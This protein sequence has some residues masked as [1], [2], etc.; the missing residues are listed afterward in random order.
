MDWKKTGTIALVIVLLLGTAGVF[1]LLNQGPAKENSRPI[2]SSKETTDPENFKK[3]DSGKGIAVTTVYL[4]PTV[5]SEN[6]MFYI[7]LDTH[8]G[9]LF[10]YEIPAISKLKVNGKV[11]TPVKWE[12][13]PSSW[14]H[15]R[16]GNLEFSSEALQEIENSDSFK[17]II[18][19]IKYDRVFE[20]EI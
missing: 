14:G 7:A 16:R 9:D 18:N 8:S 12:E 3:I 20:W 19:G 5:K 4:N 13:S 1:S 17:L 6:A 10:S 11:F 15:H 2:V